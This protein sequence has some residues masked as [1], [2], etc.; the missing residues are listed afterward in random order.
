DMLR[1]EYFEFK[2]ALGLKDYE[3]IEVMYFEQN[4][5]LFVKLINKFSSLHDAYKYLEN[6]YNEI[7]DG[8]TYK[9]LKFLDNIDCIIYCDRFKMK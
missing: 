2:N 3:I 6:S 9:I 1:N 5:E 8:N 7:I 4:L